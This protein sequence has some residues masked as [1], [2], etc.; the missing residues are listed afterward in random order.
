MGYQGTKNSAYGQSGATKQT[1]AENKFSQIKIIPDYNMPTVKIDSLILITDD[2]AAH[3][4]DAKAILRAKVIIPLAMQKHDA[5]LFNSV[6]AKGFTARGEN[7]FFEREEFIRNRVEGKW[8]ISYVQ[9]ENL[10][11][12]FFGE[13]AVLTYRNIVKEKDAMGM[14]KTWHFTWADVWVKED[15]KWKIKAVYGIHGKE[16]NTKE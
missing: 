15:G 13:I 12:Q 16:P 6:L 5:A 8:M 10:V 3:V 14:P 7:E 11:L 1:A 4:N 2:S 9:Y